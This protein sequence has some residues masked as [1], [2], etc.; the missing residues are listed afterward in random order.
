MKWNDFEDIASAL[1]LRYSDKDNVNLRFTDLRKWVLSLEGFDDHPDA[2]NE[3]IL[4]SIQAAWMSER[5]D[6]E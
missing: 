5:E 6:R 2:C 1:E 3:R 4:E